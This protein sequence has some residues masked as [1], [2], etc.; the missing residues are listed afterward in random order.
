MR[1]SKSPIRRLRRPD[2]TGANRC[3][4]CTVVNA[5]IAAVL[6]VGA[7]LVWLPAG[8]FVLALS[9]GVIYFR[10]YLVP[11]TPTLTQRYF[12]EWLLRA[13]G[14][15]PTDAR[16]TVSTAAGGSTSREAD[17]S[18][19][20][21]EDADIEELMLSEGV[22]EECAEEDDL[23]LAPRFED[24]WW[25][26]IRQF[27]DDRDRA[28]DLLA[29]VLDTDSATL[30][31]ADDDQFVVKSDG[32]AVARWTSEATFYADLAAKTTLEEWF[33][34]WERLS[35][36]TRTALAGGMRVF[37]DSCPACETAL[38]HTEE[39]RE[40]CCS[41]RQRIVSLD[42]PDCGATIFSSQY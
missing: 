35:D 14:K 22:I 17:R 28:I 37:L 26:R 1:I 3:M 4:P 23:C 42:C 21:R 5:V 39:F 41:G 18:G 27:R 13:F 10:G 25:R 9:A 12:P 29:A 40:T 34:D 15:T 19:T 32:N 36:R 2:Y 20:G 30:T 38:E 6:A 31:V 16:S 7:G 33:H 11:G 24:V 8:A